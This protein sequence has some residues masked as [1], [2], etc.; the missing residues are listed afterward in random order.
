MA[1]AE[2]N[3]TPSFQDLVGSDDK[4]NKSTPAKK[5]TPAKST[6]AKTSD[7]KTSVESKEENKDDKENTPGVSTS[8]EVKESDVQDSLNANDDRVDPDEED[9]SDT[10]PGHGIIS[11]EDHKDDD[12]EEEPAPMDLG[13][14][15]RINKMS[16]SGM[17]HL[18]TYSGGSETVI[19]DKKDVIVKPLA[20]AENKAQRVIQ[21]ETGKSRLLHPDI[22]EPAIPSEQATVQGTY[23]THVYATPVDPENDP[24]R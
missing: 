4:D 12:N 24:N 7:D 21:D 23:K 16:P 18:N 19:H 1:E 5:T 17:T 11:E 10:A 20:E 8:P 14:L 22:V 15:S 6:S 2:K 3:K 9:K 13:V